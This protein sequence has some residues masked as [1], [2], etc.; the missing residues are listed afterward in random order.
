MV[1]RS[2]LGWISH[3]KALPTWASAYLWTLKWSKTSAHESSQQFSWQHKHCSTLYALF[4]TQDLGSKKSIKISRR[5]SFFSVGVFACEIDFGCQVARSHHHHTHTSVCV[6]TSE[7]Q[8]NLSSTEFRGRLCVWSALQTGLAYKLSTATLRKS[9][10]TNR[11][12]LQLKPLKSRIVIEL[13]VESIDWSIWIPGFP[14]R[15]IQLWFI[16]DANRCLLFLPLS[17]SLPRLVLW[18]SWGEKNPRINIPGEDE[19]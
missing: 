12:Q 11:A 6:S 8:T 16:N 7:M 18:L 14:P 13:G 5:R 3:R 19:I 1:I 9:Q 10:P 4:D 2:F 17:H 15:L